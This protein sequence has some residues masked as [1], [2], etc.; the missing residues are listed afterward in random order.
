MTT[1]EMLSLEEKV[2]IVL[3]EGIHLDTT[4]SGI[5]R[6]DLYAVGNEWIEVL[7]L[8]KAW[9]FVHIRKVREKDMVKYLNRIDIPVL[10]VG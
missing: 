6:V 5:Y 3:N 8:P 9:D 10:S 7:L 1:F 2:K 4:S